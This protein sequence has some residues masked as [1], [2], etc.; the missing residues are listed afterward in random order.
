MSEPWAVKMLDHWRVVWVGES[1]APRYC[2]GPHKV[3]PGATG[4]FDD[5]VKTAAELNALYSPKPKEA[6]P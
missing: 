5:A 2:Y 1:E 3:F 4:E 6:K